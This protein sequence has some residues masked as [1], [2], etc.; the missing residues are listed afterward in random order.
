MPR[1]TGEILIVIPAHNEAPRIGEVVRGA[2][3]TVPGA[4]VLIVDDASTDGTRE[5]ALA[6]GASV[7]S[8][9]VNLGYGAGLESGYTYAR[10]HGYEIVLQMDGD[11]Q[12]LADQLP[13]ILAPVLAGEADVVLGSRYMNGGC[14]Y[15]TPFTRRAGQRLFGAIV[16]IFSGLKVTDPTSGFQCLG[17][18]AVQL[19]TS[20][21]FPYDY[22]DADILL[23]AHYA[24]L[25]I[26]EVP[27]KMAQRSEGTSM[28]AGLK[29]VYYVMKMLLSI[30][31]VIL[32]MRKWRSYVE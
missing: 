20:G 12:H 27:V 18:K 32:G 26:R 15:Q 10:E 14:G 22:P 7:M 11:G 13:L 6:A 30:F 2:R 1:G 9:P 29:P 19:Y 21:V 17:P 4:D 23:L 5:A 16:R 24:G 28:H 25:R 31:I 3:G 8:H